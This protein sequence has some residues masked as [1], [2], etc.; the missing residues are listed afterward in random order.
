M[1]RFFLSVLLLFLIAFSFSNA[2]AIS[3]GNVTTASRAST[4]QA[5]LTFNHDN[6][7]DYLVV[8]VGVES[9]SVKTVDTLTYNSVSMTEAVNQTHF[10]L[11]VCA[12]YYLTNPAS[13]I[14]TVSLELSANSA[15]RAAIAISILDAADEVPDVTATNTATNTTSISLTHVPNA[16]NGDSANLALG[17]YR[18]NNGLTFTT[19]AGQI[20][21]ANLSEGND[22]AISGV[23]AISSTS[24]TYDWTGNDSNDWAA[25][26]V[27]IRQPVIT[28]GNSTS[29][30]GDATTISKAHDNNGDLVYMCGLA[31][32]S[33]SANITDQTYNS[34]SMTQIGIEQSQGSLKDARVSYINPGA[35]GANTAAQTH[36]NIEASSF[37]VLSLDNVDQ[38]NPVDVSQASQGNGS[39]PSDTITTLTDNTLVVA[40]VNWEDGA[41][42]LSA[43]GWTECT[44]CAVSQ[45]SSS[46][47]K[48][49]TKAVATAGLVN[50]NL[51]SGAQVDDWQIFL[52]AFMEAEA[53][54]G[55]NRRIW[56]SSAM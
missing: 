1:K 19:E 54:E 51:S 42:T 17:C 7:G 53:A 47:Q 27:E 15:E 41:D 33:G 24:E 12:I 35:S 9:T 40:C 20:E 4:N 22:L 10:N 34:V 5:T 49:F 21:R 8:L 23:T 48:V 43:T 31:E 6:N 44:N 56:T 11:R 45:S 32:T 37:I 28:V 16:I 36:D 46:Q 18:D 50:F 13:G 2:N 14:N 25:V 39:D 3:I 52:T 29:Q 55:G 26:A 38:T 30:S